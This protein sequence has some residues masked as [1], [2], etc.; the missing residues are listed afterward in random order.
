MRLS[1][2]SGSALS[3]YVAAALLAGCGG[4]QP[5]IGGTRAMPNDNSG[6]SSWIAAGA[7]RQNLLYVAAD[8]NVF[9]YSYQRGIK[10]VGI[11]RPKLHGEINGLCADRLGNVWVPIARI[12]YGVSEVVEFPHGGTHPIKRLRAPED[13]LVG[14]AVDPTTGNLA[15]TSFADGCISSS[16]GYGG[17]LVYRQAKGTPTEYFDFPKVLY[18]YFCTYDDKGDLFAD[19]RSDGFV[20]VEL[21]KHGHNLREITL[22]QKFSFFPGGVQWDGR[23][24]VV[25]DQNASDVYEFSIHGKTGTEMGTTPLTGAHNVMSFWLARNRIIAPD[26]TYGDVE[27]YKFPTGGSPVKSFSISGPTGVTVSIAP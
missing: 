14:C 19:G 20:F 27:F 3:C 17:L 26:N 13:D 2:V 15:V 4:S 23:H 21:P 25:G 22:D 1:G 24:A 6:A 12:S 18:F 9:V 5:P 7:K 10:L 11:V 16:C 8:N